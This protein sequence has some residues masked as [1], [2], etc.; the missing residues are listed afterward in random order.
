[1]YLLLRRLQDQARLAASREDPPSK[2]RHLALRSLRPHLSKQ[3]MCLLRI[4][5]ALPRPPPNAQLRLLRR[6]GSPL[7]H[8]LPQ[9]PPRATPRPRSCLYLPPHNVRLGEH[10]PG[11]FVSL[12]LLR[13]AA[14]VLE[15]KSRPH[16]TA[17]QG[18]SRNGG[19]ERRP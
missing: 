12:R 18:G 2:P 8:L 19:V 6:Q 16:R 4:P 9:R 17:L 13:R 3:Y 7:T 15:R 5:E 14:L 10:N 11:I 1:M